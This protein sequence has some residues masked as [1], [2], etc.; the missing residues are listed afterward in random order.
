VIH[1]AIAAAE[2]VVRAL[3]VWIVAAAALAT[4]ALYAVI[5]AGWGVW[6]AVRAAMPRR[7]PTACAWRPWK[8]ARPLAPAV[9][10]T[11]P[12]GAPEALHAIPARPTPSWARTDK[13][14]A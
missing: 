2:S 11:E 9:A 7:A 8:R 3:L 12:P 10:L 6:R 1:E 13:D 5:A 14:A 4:A